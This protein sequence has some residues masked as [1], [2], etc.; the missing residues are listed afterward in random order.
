MADR[1]PKAPENGERHTMIHINRRDF[2]QLTGAACL[3]GATPNALG[4]SH[5][6]PA[7][8]AS[9]RPPLGAVI[10]IHDGESVAKAIE[11]VHD[12]GF[13]TC[14]IGF[15]NLTSDVAGPVK[16]ALERYGM[17]ATAFSEH[18]P[19]VFERVFNFY[20][21]P[22]TIGII[23]PSMRAAR[24]RN[25]K[26]AADI[27]VQCNIPAIHTHCGFIPEDPNDTLYPQAVSAVREIGNYCK[28][29]SLDFLCETGQETPITLLRM[30]EDTGLENVFVNMDVANLIECGKGNPVD[31][32]EI[33]GHL[34]RGTHI[35]DGR[36]PTNPREFGEGVPIGT[37]KVDFPRVLEQ[38][39]Q[40]GYR[41]PL[42]VETETS[43]PDNLRILR[44]SRQ[45]LVNLLD[46][47]YS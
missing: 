2:M 20:E 9:S 29:R 21:G 8:S 19:D 13:P 15:K 37:G 30:I 40:V 11:Q 39:K 12:L 28:E 47:I 33:L 44:E 16:E 41:G 5:M 36:F 43:G 35:K 3:G 24:I 14:Q 46:K 27:A 7:A 34:V 17:Q 26:L 10:W 1:E 25:L 38:L 23:P 18:G 45:F 32:M 31:A 6:S 22:S 4:S 42:T